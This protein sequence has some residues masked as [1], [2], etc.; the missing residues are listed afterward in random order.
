MGYI[1]SGPISRMFMSSIGVYKPAIRTSW[2]NFSSRILNRYQLA[3]SFCWDWT[4]KFISLA[5]GAAAGAAG[6]AEDEDASP[7]GFGAGS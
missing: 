6:A 1:E 3:L 7:P 5:S 2:N 4:Y